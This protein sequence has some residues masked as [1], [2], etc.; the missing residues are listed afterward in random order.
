MVP[1]D[2]HIREP[3]GKLLE[4]GAMVRLHMVDYGV[5]QGAPV[6][7]GVDVFKKLPGNCRID[8]IDQRC[9]IV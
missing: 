8:R 4:I 1:N 6:E 2:F 9:F 5:I 7:R 3:P